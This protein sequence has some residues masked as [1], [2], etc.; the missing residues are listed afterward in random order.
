ML[1][2]TA[3]SLTAL[4]LTLIACE[5][6]TV[7]MSVELRTDFVPGIEFVAVETWAED[8]P[9]AHDEVAAFRSDDYATAPRRVAEIDGLAPNAERRITVRL[10]DADRAEVARRTVLVEHVR[11]RGV[12][13]LLTRSCRDVTCGA[14]E[15]CYAGRCQPEACETVGCVSECSVDADCLAAACA[16]A[17]CVAGACFLEPIAGAC[18]AG[19]YCDAED[20]C[21]PE[22]TARDA[23]VPPVDAGAGSD[24]GIDGGVDAGTDA[25]VDAGSA[26]RIA[27][28][29]GGVATWT[30]HLTTGDGPTGPIRAAFT[31]RAAEMAVVTDD[32]VH[33]LD[34]RTWQW[35]ASAPRA[36]V[37]P[38]LVGASIWDAVLVSG[39]NN[40]VFYGP[41]G[42][43]ELTWSPT[44]R[45]ATFV[46]FTARA[47]FGA[48][49]SDPDAA[50]WFSMYGVFSR[51]DDGEGWV[52]A[53]P[54]TECPGHFSVGRNLVMVA[55]DG[56]GPLVMNVSIY[57]VD[58]PFRFIEK[59]TSS[60]FAPFTR[61]GAP[62]VWDAE[63]MVYLRGS[64]V[65]FF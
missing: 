18:P 29:A 9:G 50:P 23:G 5:P 2:R 35:V 48:D 39:T 53:D 38:D 17:S 21:L 24:A 15:S 47:D 6:G 43:W 19:T 31:S 10:L 8:G 44:T 54:S 42:A 57:D 20:G 22:P 26:F 34:G 58:C 60:M 36:T 27:E 16:S 64:L 41:D 59:T 3:P 49:W 62:S 52:T 55:T 11:D 63:A 40:L 28:F 12:T 45:S 13:V 33:Y 46:A 4:A 56:F 7:S 25:G 30:E 51:P 37:F 32:R 1:R 61:P 14:G 65:V